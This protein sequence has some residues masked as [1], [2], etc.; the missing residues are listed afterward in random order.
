MEVFTIRVQENIAKQI[1]YLSKEENKPQAELIRELMNT[2]VKEK[3]L[4][5]LLEKYEK[6]ELTLRTLA[7]KLNIPLWK[8]QEFLGRIT[9]P[10]GKEDLQ[11][12][13]R[14]IEGL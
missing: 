4:Q 11:R 1:A 5:V 13:L 6:K 14:L 10:Y 9:F 12:D 8:A 3:Q 7:K 2:A